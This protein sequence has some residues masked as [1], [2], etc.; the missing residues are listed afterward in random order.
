MSAVVD[1]RRDDCAREVRDALDERR[2]CYALDERRQG[3]ALYERRGPRYALLCARGE[4]LRAVRERRGPRYALYERRKL[5]YALYERRKLRYSQY[6]FTRG[7]SSA[8]GRS[9]RHS[10]ICTCGRS[11]SYELCVAAG[12]VGRRHNMWIRAD[13]PRATRAA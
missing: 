12:I 9:T 10:T 2:Q 3:Y 8:W 13:T 1:A 7:E 11:V 6:G 5:R 4:G